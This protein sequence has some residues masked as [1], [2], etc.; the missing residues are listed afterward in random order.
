MSYKT[1][2][3]NVA[4][5]CLRFHAT[6]KM[7]S[8]Y[9]L[10]TKYSVAASRRWA[11]I[12]AFWQWLGRAPPGGG[13]SGGSLRSSRQAVACHPFTRPW[14]AMPPEVPSPP[15]LLCHMVFTDGHF[16]DL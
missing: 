1:E 4:K 8:D 14:A 11:L 5:Q 12:Y 3:G 7:V 13:T 10:V 9:Q 16:H 2:R 6:V 15:R